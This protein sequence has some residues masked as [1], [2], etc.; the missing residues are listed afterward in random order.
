MPFLVLA[1]SALSLGFLHGLGA[2][3]LMAI[4][5]LSVDGRST[6]G[7]RHRRVLAAAMQFAAGH[8]VLLGVGAILA[9]TFG[10]VVPATVESGAERVG[11]VLLVLLGAAGLWS[12]WTG[13]AYG[14]LHDVGSGGWRWHVHFGRRRQ[15]DR[16]PHDTTTLPA[17]MGAIFAVSSL[18]MLMLLT[19]FGAEA[20]SFG[21]PVLLALIAL[22]GVGVLLSMSLFGVVL[23]RVLSLAAIERLGRTAGALVAV[24]SISLGFYWMLV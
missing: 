21:L 22:F 12:L 6:Q 17:V 8:A 1:G 11:G 16:A 10:W 13:R 2:D 9:V 3:H 20:G 15:H 18:R 14:H 19:P 24:A 5:A 23:A 7:D 4:A